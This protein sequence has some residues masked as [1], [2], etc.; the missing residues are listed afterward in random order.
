MKSTDITKIYMGDTQGQKLFLGDE[1]IWPVGGPTPTGSTNTLNTVYHA[2]RNPGPP[3]AYNCAT[4]LHKQYIQSAYNTDILTK[5]ELSGGTE[6]PVS[7]TYN[8][9]PVSGSNV[10]NY[11]FTGNTLTPSLFMQTDLESIVIPSG[12]TE[13]KYDC[14]QGCNLLTAVTISDS[15][16]TIGGEA[17]NQ[18]VLLPTIT[19]PS[20]V[21]NIGASV[22]SNC[23]GLQEMIFVGTTPPALG[24]EGLGSTGYTFPIYVPCEA[25]ETYKTAYPAYAS[26]ITCVEPE[27]RLAITYNVVSTTGT[28]I[29]DAYGSALSCFSKAELGDGTV[30]D[31]KSNYFNGNHSFSETGLTTVYYTM[32]GTV[33]NDRVFQ[34]CTSIT[35]V[36]IPEGVAVIGNQT[37]YN[38]TSITSVTLS[39]TVIALNN[40]C[41]QSNTSLPSVTIPSSVTT[42]NKFA[43]NKAS[44]MTEM[45]FEGTTPPTFTPIGDD[46]VVGV[47]SYPIYV[48]CESVEAY[49]TA[50]G[51]TFASRITCVG[52]ET[53]L[54][55]T[56]N[57]TST[58]R[59]TNILYTGTTGFSK[60]EL[61]DGTEIPV[62]KTYMFPETGQTKVYYTLTG[63][64]TPEK[65]FYN[66]K[67]IV[68][69][70]LPN[71]GLEEVGASSFTNCWNIVNITIPNSVQRI[72]DSAFY[73]CCGATG[74]IN[75][76]SDCVVGT[77]AFGRCRSFTGITVQSGATLGYRAFQM[78]SS[79]INITIKP[80]VTFVSGATFESNYESLEEVI[81][82]GAPPQGQPV[83]IFTT[84]ES[85]R[86]PIYVPND[87]VDA[88]KQWFDGLT[89]SRVCPISERTIPA[90][91]K[92]LAF[93]RNKTSGGD[94]YVEADYSESG[95]NESMWAEYEFGLSHLPTGSTQVHIL[96]G[97]NYRFA[98]IDTAGNWSVRRGGESLTITSSP[99][100]VG[101]SIG[102]LVTR[103]YTFF[104]NGDNIEVDG[105][106]VGSVTDPGTSPDS[107]HPRFFSVNGSDDY[108][109]YGAVGFLF[110][111]KIGYKDE[112]SS[113]IAHYVPAQRRSDDVYGLWDFVTSTF[114]PVNNGASGN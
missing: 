108:T 11:T 102:T 71:S 112:G 23:T 44:G 93:L 52:L 10:V 6:I 78:G 48:P 1:L 60:A 43:F 19:I 42:F 62:A 9:F 61:E 17:F 37:F 70:E 76:P 59:N 18:C 90:A 13:I 95:F 92:R 106:V 20:G 3:L 55:V 73:T 35:D 56:Y 47:G 84:N 39:D 46:P 27:T 75:I 53:R 51:S 25:V 96:S 114:L 80:D 89:K 14:F 45:I 34:S 99:F 33:I 82:E 85:Y 29:T 101:G 57:V 4:I 79:V 54:A 7:N 69:I 98:E 110:R 26:R 24:S 81:F 77:N 83:T 103:T 67:N 91:Y 65:A 38:C 74:T 66:L 94:G 21:T 64:S 109:T 100:T 105:V 86:Y 32:S 87:Q 16:T 22:F 8:D 63:T 72:D 107:I 41:F 104:K 36:V 40:G 28:K 68:G 30:I 12:V 58:T 15:V 113:L 2:T 31:I 50:V 88:W 5:A 111:G 49:K 97:D